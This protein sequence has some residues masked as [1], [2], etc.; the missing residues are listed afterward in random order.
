MASIEEVITV[1]TEIMTPTTTIP[2]INHAPG[3]DIYN[4]TYTH[5]NSSTITQFLNRGSNYV[6]QTVYDCGVFLDYDSWDY[7]DKTNCLLLI[8]MFVC[9]MIV[10][11]IISKNIFTCMYNAYQRR[12]EQRMRNNDEDGHEKLKQP[13]IVSIHDKQS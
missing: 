6:M 13:D 9:T 8:I 10:L 1:A 4:L 7:K 3:P 2:T 12:M 11:Q 5:P